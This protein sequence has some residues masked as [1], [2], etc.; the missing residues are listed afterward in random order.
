VPGDEAEAGDQLPGDPDASGGRRPDPRVVLAVAAG[1]ALG[2]PARYAVAEAVGVGANGFPWATFWTNVSGSLLLGFLVALIVR[3]FPPSRY[4]RP[5]A[6][7]GFVGAFT[8]FSTLMVETDLLVDHGHAATAVAY[9]TASLV[10]G[11]AAVWLGILGG[12]LVPI[13]SR[14]EAQP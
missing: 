3:R 8:T 14:P 1:G 4:L 11:I 12:R 9:V 5:F 7:T 2:A 13:R 10:A 6:A